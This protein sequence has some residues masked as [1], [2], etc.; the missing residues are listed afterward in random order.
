MLV[1]VNESFVK[2]IKSILSVSSAQS[3]P[4]VGNALFTNLSIDTV[5][6]L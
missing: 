1:S 6:P 2:S 4:V 3:N 5:T